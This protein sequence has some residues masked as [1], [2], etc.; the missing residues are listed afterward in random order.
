[1]TG[2]FEVDPDAVHETATDLADVRPE[3]EWA[4][5]YLG[6]YDHSGSDHVFGEYGASAEQEAFQEAWVAEIVTTADAVGQ[7]AEALHVAADRYATSD[8]VAVA[9]LGGR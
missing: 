2:A 9:R 7:T 1:V 4:R 6:T 8:A 5:K 3:L